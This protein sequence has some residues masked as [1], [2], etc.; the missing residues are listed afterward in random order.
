MS[1]PL[2]EFQNVEFGYEQ[3]DAV[4]QNCSLIVE[5]GS[6]IV[7]LG[8]SGCGKSTLLR[9]AAGFLTPRSGKIL[10]AGTEILAPDRS[11]LLIYQEQDQLFPWQR[12]LGNTTLPLLCGPERCSRAEAEARAREALEQVGLGDRMDAFPGQLS[13]GMK[14]RAVL[15]RALAIRS[16][17]LLL[18]EPFASLDA[19]SRESLQELIVDTWRHHGTTVLFVTHDIREA[20]RI[21]GEIW[22]MHPAGDS[23]GMERIILEGVS[24]RELE[25][26]GADAIIRSVR[27]RLAQ[28]AQSPVTGKELH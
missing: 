8:P 26:P 5:Q 3:G 19:F 4:I 15:A 17:V 14:Q 12:L 10:S 28:S 11:R 21:G 2:L 24:P 13:G 25:T 22:F 18:D 27:G 20:V 1:A 23:R 7:L 6:F 9:L 16:R